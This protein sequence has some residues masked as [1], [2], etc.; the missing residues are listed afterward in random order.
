[1]NN[2]VNK[3]YEKIREQGVKIFVGTSEPTIVKSMIQVYFDKELVRFSLSSMISKPMLI[4]SEVSAYR[5]N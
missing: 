2:T 3:S 5:Q 4:T 1:M